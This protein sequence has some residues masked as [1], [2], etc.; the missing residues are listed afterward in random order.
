MI[1]SPRHIN[2]DNTVTHLVVHCMLGDLT[3]TSRMARAIYS[4]QNRICTVIYLPLLL[5]RRMIYHIWLFP[6][7][8]MQFIRH[9]LTGTDLYR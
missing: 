3:S 9:D 5:E 4:V 6:L 8:L 2:T 7:M 1:T